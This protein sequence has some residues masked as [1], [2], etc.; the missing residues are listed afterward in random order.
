[1]KLKGIIFDVDGTMADTEEV[2]RQAFNQAFQEFD[3]NWHW[4]KSDY[5]KL[6]FIS[7]GKERFKICLNED[8]ELKSKVKD[9]GLFIKELHKCKSDHYREML[10]T[11]HIQLRP[12]I[13]RLI[14][15]AQDKELQLGIATSSCLANLN[16]LINTA[17]DIDP[18]EIFN[19]IVSSDTVSDK[20]PSPVVYQ[21]A[22]AGLGLMPET[23]VAIED[24]QNGN[25]AALS[26]GLHTIITTHAYTIDND[27]T[28]ASLVT[29]H[30]GEPNNA[31]IVAQGDTYDKSYV[32]VELLD[33]FISHSLDNTPE[34]DL[35]EI[36]SNIN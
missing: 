12:G 24:T 31:F 11:K 28:G 20:K 2:H 23:C 10:A 32:D 30:L 36:T 22:L 5:Y 27:F 35:P 6:L 33:N 3:L 8:K 21:C 4:S 9:P 16:T 15:E 29:N 1:M 34:F 26:T 14:N 18:K 25:M 17:L 7:G 13:K 19:T